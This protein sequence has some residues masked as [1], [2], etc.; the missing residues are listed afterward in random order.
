[1]AKNTAETAKNV[2]NITKTVTERQQMR[3][4]SVYY[5]GM[6]DM[7]SYK[8]PEHVVYKCDLNEDSDFNTLLKDSMGSSDFICSTIFV[9]SQNYSNSDII[10]VGIEDCDNLSVGLIRTVL[11]NGCKVYFVIQRYKAQR[12]KLRFFESKKPNEDIFEFIDCNRIIDF[13]PL[14]MRGTNKNFVFTLHH[15]VSF[16]YE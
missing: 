5:N 2:I 11:V 8:N 3:S 1:M 7:S 15:H 10:I 9:N 13:K 14:I 16:D 4:V 12:N 6:F